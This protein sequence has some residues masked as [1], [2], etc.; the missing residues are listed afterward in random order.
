MPTGRFSPNPELSWQPM[1]ESDVQSRQGAVV[2]PT[3]D[4]YSVTTTP[5]TCGPFGKSRAVTEGATYCKF[6]PVTPAT[7]HRLIWTLTTPAPAGTEQVT[8]LSDTHATVRHA[9]SPTLA[10]TMVEL[11]FPK[12]DPNNVI[13]LFP[14]VDVLVGST[15]VSVGGSYWNPAGSD[16]RI[17]PK[18]VSISSV[19]DGENDCW[20]G[21]VHE[22]DVSETQ[23]KVPEA[24]PTMHDPSRGR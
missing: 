1:A 11:L 14:R 16:A 8:L 24:P 15:A 23:V 7:P 13:V 20:T 22:P 10:L 17:V 5:P 12:S 9:V 18:T 2:L 6:C 19:S 21:I 4:P 3:L